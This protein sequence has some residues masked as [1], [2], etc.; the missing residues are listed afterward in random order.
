MGP[1][2]SVPAPLIDRSALLRQ[3]ARPQRSRP[4]FLQVAALED[5]KDRLQMVTKAFT[6][7]VIIAA[8]PK[9]WAAAYPQARVISDDDVLDLA[10]DSCDLIVHALALHWANDPLGQLIQCRR[11]LRGD[12]LL[13]AALLGGRSLFQL[14]SA[15]AEAEIAVMG[16]V[17]PRVLPMA[18]IRELGS[19]LQRAGLALPVADSFEIT[20]QYR[21]LRHIMHDLRAMGESNAQQVRL[22]KFTPRRLFETAQDI[23]AEHF[24]QPDGLLPVLFEMIWLTGWAPDA[25]QQQPLRPGS[26]Q[27]RLSDALQVPERPLQD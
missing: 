14:R 18:E 13:L 23:Y 11:A 10:P 4:D 21:D 2:M 7:M 25:S 22:K 3:R 9:I 15:L 19:L 24:A 8:D 16:G 17:S 20:A 27:T 1:Y 26:A 6:D 5:L 12:G